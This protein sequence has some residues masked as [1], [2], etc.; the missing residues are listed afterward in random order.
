MNKWTVAENL[1]ANSESQQCL[2]M[3]MV[4]PFDNI[5]YSSLLIV[6]VMHINITRKYL[7][8]FR[9]QKWRIKRSLVFDIGEYFPTKAGENV[10]YFSY[11]VF[12]Q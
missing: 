2:R 4:K 3:Q 9:L 12:W 8:P 7:L 1:P 11:F 5:K 6:R 10:N